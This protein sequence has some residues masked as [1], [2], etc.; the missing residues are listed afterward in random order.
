[1]G[2]NRGAPP[3]VLSVLHAKSCTSADL[4]FA[5]GVLTDQTAPPFVRVTRPASCPFRI[6][7]TRTIGVRTQPS[8][9]RR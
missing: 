6:V 3:R 2:S 9:D 1:M 4:S 7:C 5:I 8:F